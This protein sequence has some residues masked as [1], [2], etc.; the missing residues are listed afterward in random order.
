[1]LKTNGL[2]GGTVNDMPQPVGLGTTAAIV[3]VAV[4]RESFSVIVARSMFEPDPNGVAGNTAFAPS[5]CAAG[6]ADQ[7]VAPFVLSSSFASW[8]AMVRPALSTPTTSTLTG[9]PEAVGS[10]LSKGVSCCPLVGRLKVT[11]SIDSSCGWPHPLHPAICADAKA[12][13]AAPHPPTNV[14]FFIRS[15]ERLAGVPRVSADHEK[16]ALDQK[17][18]EACGV[19]ATAVA[20]HLELTAEHIG[21]LR[22]G[23]RAVGELHDSLRDLGRLAIFVFKEVKEI[24]GTRGQK[25]II[26]AL[27]TRVGMPS[28]DRR[29]EFIASDARGAALR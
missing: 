9:N 27:K 25:P 11:S 18:N 23:S 24:I 29:P 12:S 10:L 22:D 3:R 8:S 19:R 15:P 2:E 6:P 14:C 26:D 16:A 4:R 20:F 13:S 28:G 1:M 17:L 5:S 7:S 21:N